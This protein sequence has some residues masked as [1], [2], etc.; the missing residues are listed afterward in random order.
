MKIK[1]KLLSSGFGTHKYYVEWAGDWTA[2]DLIDAV[3][4]T[5]GNYGG[6][7]DVSTQNGEYYTGIVGVYYD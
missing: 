2:K 7:V 4:G 1:K 6:Y 5:T 3:D